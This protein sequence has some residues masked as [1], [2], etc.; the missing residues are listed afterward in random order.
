MRPRRFTVGRTDDAVHPDTM[1]A[2]LAEFLGTA[3]FVFAAEGS[4][5]SLGMVEINQSYFVFLVMHACL[6]LDS[7]FAFLEAFIAWVIKSAFR[8]FYIQK[9]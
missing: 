5:L 1:R 3:I 8:E 4:L 9:S 6:S 7:S 2:A